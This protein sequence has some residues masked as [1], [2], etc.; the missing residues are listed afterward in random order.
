MQNNARLL[1]AQHLPTKV[2]GGLLVAQRD[3]ACLGEAS[4]G[5]KT[6]NG[7][8]AAG[9]AAIAAAEARRAAMSAEGRG[10]PAGTGQLQLAMSR[11]MS[12]QQE[13]LL[14][15]ARSEEAGQAPAQLP[16]R[17]PDPFRTIVPASAFRMEERASFGAYTACWHVC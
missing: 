12:G 13:A 7:E 11:A 1:S 16:G 4:L 10:Q 5:R 9:Q 14:L 17:R 2:L 8:I 6:G 3:T 15:S